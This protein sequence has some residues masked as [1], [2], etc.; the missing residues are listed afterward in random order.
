MSTK[1]V[2]FSSEDF[3]IENAKYGDHHSEFVTQN[4]D[5][6]G[7][8]SSELFLATGSEEN[9]LIGPG[10]CLR[11]ENRM[12]G[13]IEFNVSELAV[14]FM[15]LLVFQRDDGKISGEPPYHPDY[16]TMNTSVLFWDIT[17]DDDLEEML[18]HH[19]PDLR[20]HAVSFGLGDEVIYLLEARNEYL[21]KSNNGIKLGNL[22]LISKMSTP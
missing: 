8:F 13:T 3:E 17:D 12:V 16:R 1:N 15:Y 22:L 18:E 9:R 21:E 6:F 4:I 19:S 2:E 20:L 10:K 7:Q 11:T 14:P 5:F